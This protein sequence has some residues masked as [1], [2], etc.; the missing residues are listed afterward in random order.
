MCPLE[1]LPH[2]SVL[3]VHL[4]GPLPF[5]VGAAGPLPVIQAESPLPTGEVVSLAL[6]GGEEGAEKM[7][8]CSG[9]GLAKGSKPNLQGEEMAPKEACFPQTPPNLVPCTLHP[10]PLHGYQSLP[11]QC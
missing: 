5:L 10:A 11:P 8:F 1:R 6:R 3:H 9:V 2:S 4:P 7:G